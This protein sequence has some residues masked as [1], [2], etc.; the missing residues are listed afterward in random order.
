V[1]AD[2]AATFLHEYRPKSANT[3]RNALRHLSSLWRKHFRAL[4]LVT[5]NPWADVPPPPVVRNTPRAPTDETI[6][7]F[8]AYLEQRYPGWDLI[9]HFV[10]AK[11]F[12]GC[13]TADLCGVLSD[14]LRDGRLHF[15]ADQT[16]THTARSVPLPPDLYAALDRLKGPTY[17]WE[18][19][20]AGA[21]TY[22]RNQNKTTAK[23]FAPSL[24]YWGIG[25]IFAEFNRSRPG[26]PRLRPHDLRRLALTR[27]ALAFGADVAAKAI[28]VDPQTARR[29]YID[30]QQAYDADA[31]YEKMG[32]WWRFGGGKGWPPA[33]KKGKKPTK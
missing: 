19:Y 15:D 26:K 10:R 7:E 20:A 18:A 17:L 13:R 3:V 14:Q 4:K 32:D 28:G 21:T 6:D 22:R 2:D 23:P 5:A 24:L 29:Y 11:A 8:F 30:G 9:K 33:S 1:T 31:V 27:A 25:N 12:I 16:K